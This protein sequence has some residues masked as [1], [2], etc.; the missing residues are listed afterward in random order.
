MP[1]ENEVQEVKPAQPVKENFSGEYV[2][3]LR[4]ESKSYRLRA[5][6]A[7]A[8]AKAAK[9]IADKAEAEAKTKIETAS[10]A[11]EQRIIRAELKAAAL[12]AGMVDLDGLKLADL[13]S[14]KLNDEGEVEGADALMAELKEKKPY[15]FQS[16]TTTSSTTQ[17]PPKSEQKAKSAMELTPEEY[18]AQKAALIKQKR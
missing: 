12:K 16:G 13:E 11:A 3:E 14:I 17:T 9:E 2:R 4:E 18:Q 8:S 15:L 7:E 5:Q 1:D 6:E 10:K